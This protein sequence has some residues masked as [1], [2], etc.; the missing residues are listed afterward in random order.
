[1]LFFGVFFCL[2]SNAKLEPAFDTLRVFMKK[3]EP[4]HFCGT[5]S[6]LFLKGFGC[7]TQSSLCSS[8]TGDWHTERGTADVVQAYRVAEFN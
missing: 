1:M 3:Q 4:P 2:V 5:A 8:Q 7:L 6:W